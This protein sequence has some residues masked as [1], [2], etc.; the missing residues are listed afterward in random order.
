[1]LRRGQQS[2]SH[3]STSK[4]HFQSLR[5][6]GPVNQLQDDRKGSSIKEAKKK[7]QPHLAVTVRY[8][9]TSV[10]SDRSADKS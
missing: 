6:C 2:V 8:T 5:F 3:S 4:S 10:N 9:D 7:H 1:M